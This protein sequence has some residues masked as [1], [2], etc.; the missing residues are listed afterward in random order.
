MLIAKKFNKKIKKINNKT[1]NL[2]VS[3]I[4][5]KDTDTGEDTDKDTDTDTGTV[6]DY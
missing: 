2:I 3:V 5:F 4:F 1:Q 6:T